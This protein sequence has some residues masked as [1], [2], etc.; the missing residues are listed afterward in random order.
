MLVFNEKGFKAPSTTGRYEPDLLCGRCDG[1]LGA[2][3]ERALILLRDLRQMEIG[4]KSETDFVINCGVHPFRVD[5]VDDFIRF[6]CG[7]L[8]KY[9]SVPEDN[10]SKIHID[11]YRETFEN[12]CF[13]GAPIPLDVDVFLER[14]LF[15]ATRYDD[16]C[17]VF[18]YSTPSVSV[19]KGRRMAWFS[20]GGFIVYVKVDPYGPS[21]FA[22]P[23]CWMRGRKKCHF[24]VDIRALETNIGIIESMDATREDLARLN[25]KIKFP[26]RPSR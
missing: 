4:T 13:H 24:N 11:E 17:G 20:V 19:L 2:Y 14:D 8:W 26:E 1:T 5:K 15:S 12:V 18:Y 21:D 22:P 23:K 3:E 6:A 9:M 7:I 25:R 10:P 16:P